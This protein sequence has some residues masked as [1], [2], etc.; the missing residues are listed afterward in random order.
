MAKTKRSNTTK[1]KQE[2]KSFNLKASKRTKIIFGSFLML[3][4]IGLFISFLSYFFNWQAD[5]SMMGNV[6]DRSEQANNWLTSL[7]LI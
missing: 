4:A 1:P 3:F 2:K 6:M 7:E 5:Q